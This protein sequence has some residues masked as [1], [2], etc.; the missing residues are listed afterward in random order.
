MS[1][2][3]LVVLGLRLIVVVVD[4]LVVLTRVVVS[5]EVE[6]SHGG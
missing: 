1:E 5:E 2:A 6:E 4:V 3:R